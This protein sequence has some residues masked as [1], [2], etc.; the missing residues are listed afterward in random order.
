VEDRNLSISLHFNDH[1]PDRPTLADTGMSPCWILFEFL[2]EENQKWG[3][4]MNTKKTKIMPV[5]KKNGPHQQVFSGGNE[6]EIVHNLSIL[7]VT[8]M[9]LALV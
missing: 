1:F 9:S 5:T 2:A 8:L 3:L 4:K 7:E 6:I